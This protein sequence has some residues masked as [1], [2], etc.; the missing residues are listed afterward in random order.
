MPYN[1][2]PLT[3]VEYDLLYNWVLN[4]APDKN[5]FVKFSDNP[6]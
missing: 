3:A 2:P 6:L 5:G 4:G 1:K